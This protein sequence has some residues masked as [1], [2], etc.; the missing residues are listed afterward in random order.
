MKY[1]ILEEALASVIKRLDIT[2]EEIKKLKK[3]KQNP[4]VSHQVKSNNP[5]LASV[6]QAKYIKALGGDPWTE[7]TKKEAGETIDKLLE[8]KKN[9]EFNNKIQ[10]EVIE[11]QEVD[12][13]DVGIDDEGLL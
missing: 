13:E 1:E 9:K 11:P 7:M 10:D 12:T 3:D 6:D 5:G 8:E 4:K 2:E